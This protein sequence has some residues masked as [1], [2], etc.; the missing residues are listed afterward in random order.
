[1]IFFS[2]QSKMKFPDYFFL[3]I[4]SKLLILSDGN[5]F[6]KFL[7][8]LTLVRLSKNGLQFFNQAVNLAFYK[9]D[10]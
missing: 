6:I 7:T 3:L 8:I 5:L 1:M 2:K 9:M 10:I 4:S